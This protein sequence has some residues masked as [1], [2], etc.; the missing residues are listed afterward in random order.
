MVL[1]NIIDLRKMNKTEIVELLKENNKIV[2]KN[3]SYDYLLRIA[4]VN[5]TPE[6]LQELKDKIKDLKE[7]I[8]TLN[9]KSNK[10]I[11]LEE[12]ESLETLNVF[13]DINSI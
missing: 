12:L 4:I 5:F 9:S 10:D 2:T 6:K 1:D 8:D 3:D 13:K 11:W 7:T